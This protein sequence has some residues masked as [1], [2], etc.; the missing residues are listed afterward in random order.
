M[1]DDLEDRVVSRLSLMLEAR[2]P[3]RACE[4]LR[5]VPQ[6][7]SE[8][9]WDGGPGGALEGISPKYMTHRPRRCALAVCVIQVQT[10]T[11]WT[12]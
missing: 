7:A 1:D 10:P 3:A 11:P 6:G 5:E 12:L 9:S 2:N 4:D 8:E